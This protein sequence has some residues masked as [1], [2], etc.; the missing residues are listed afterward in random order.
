VRAIAK[1]PTHFG[2]WILRL[3][4]GQV[5]DFRLGPDREPIQI[6][7]SILVLLNP[8]SKTCGE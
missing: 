5:L 4:S 1:I 3:S 7:F 6:V 8:K 2:F